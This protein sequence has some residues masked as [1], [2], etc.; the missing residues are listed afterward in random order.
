[1]RHVSGSA[2]QGPG[3]AVL[4]PDRFPV[5]LGFN[6]LIQLILDPARDQLTITRTQL[7]EFPGKRREDARKYNDRGMKTKGCYG[8]GREEKRRSGLSGRRETGGGRSAADVLS[9]SFSGMSSA[10]SPALLQ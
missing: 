1:M 10:K 3:V 4:W 8:K 6:L 7:R 9:L 5:P 2:V